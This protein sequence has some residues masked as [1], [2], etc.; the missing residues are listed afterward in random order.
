M[1]DDL[2]V[3]VLT[4][5]FKESDCKICV[6]IHRY[7]L[8]PHADGTLIERLSWRIEHIGHRMTLTARENK[9][10]LLTLLDFGSQKS[11]DVSLSVFSYLLKFV[12]CN[13]TRFVRLCNIG[14]NLIQ[15]RLWNLNITETYVKTWQSSHSIQ[16]KADPK[17]T[18]NLEKFLFPG[19]RLRF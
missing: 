6:G 3:N 7:C 15:C 10:S 16:L 1:L 19:S 12:N 2:S 18:D 13:N 5:F 8:K 4:V 11:F 17:R 14:E 9:L